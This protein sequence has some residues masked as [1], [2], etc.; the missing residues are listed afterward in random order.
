MGGGR[1]LTDLVQQHSCGRR[2]DG[3]A[4][5]WG[6]DGL[7]QSSPPQVTFDALSAGANHVCGVATDGRV[8]C[9]GDDGAGQGS[10]P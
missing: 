4:L 3:S 6:D 9:W 2:N 7:G 10:P 1:Q 8:F 5:C